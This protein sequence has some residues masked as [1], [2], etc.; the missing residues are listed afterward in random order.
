MRLAEAMIRAG[1]QLEAFL[2][3]TAYEGG[4][5]EERWDPE[6][7]ADC[8]ESACP[9]HPPESALVRGLVESL[10]SATDYPAF[11]AGKSGADKDSRSRCK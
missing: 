9:S 3:A 2:I 8:R 10:P 4:G 7:R 5:R 6:S 1:A 11:C